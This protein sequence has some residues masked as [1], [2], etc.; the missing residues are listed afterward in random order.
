MRMDTVAVGLIGSAR[1]SEEVIATSSVLALP[2]IRCTA[3]HGGADDKVRKTRVELVHEPFRGTHEGQ[4]GFS[5][6]VSISRPDARVCIQV[7][8]FN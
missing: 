8:R 2:L 6:L 7:T 3:V 5:L 4:A 1:G